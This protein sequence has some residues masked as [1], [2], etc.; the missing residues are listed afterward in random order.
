[1]SVE[2]ARCGHEKWH[3]G[4]RRCNR[5]SGIKPCLCIGFS[6]RQEEGTVTTNL[7]NCAFCKSSNASLKSVTEPRAWWWVE[8]Y[9]CEARGPRTVRE[10]LARMAWELRA[11]IS[12]YINSKRVLE[13]RVEQLSK[14]L[15]RIVADC[16]NEYPTIA[17]IAS[18][19]LE[20]NNEGDL[21]S[22]DG[23]LPS[24]GQAGVG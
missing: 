6:V 16:K 9:H 1:M 14:G 4:V 15:R 21:R 24:Q 8:C 23:D 19:T 12:D 7:M 2:C 11:D 13:E 22:N 5:I 3:H 20:E 10:D 18:R 17:R